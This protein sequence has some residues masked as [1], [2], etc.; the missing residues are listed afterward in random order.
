MYDKL[1]NTI[2]NTKRWNG[3]IRDILIHP[4]DLREFKAEA[5]KIVPGY[6]IKETTYEM[7]CDIPIKTSPDCQVGNVYFGIR[8]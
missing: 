1:L 6:E 3:A 5:R 8:Y 2:L 7:I 4:E